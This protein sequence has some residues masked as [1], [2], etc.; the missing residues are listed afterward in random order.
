MSKADFSFIRYSN[1]WE[2]TD[3]LLNALDIRKGE[4]GI[5]IASAGDNTL[6]MLLKEP[7]RIYAFDLNPTQL[8][9][10][11]LKMSCFRC[12]SYRET[13][14]FLGV[15]R[16]ERVPLYSRVREA[17]S[18]QARDYFDSHIEII[19]QGVIHC[20]R[21]ENFFRIFRNYVIPMFSSREEFRSFVR[22]DNLQQQIDFYNEHINNHRLRAMFRIYF[23]YKVMGRLGR[24]SSFYDHVE[25][26]EHS[27]S[28]IRSRFEFG[29]SHAVNAFNPY[30]NYIVCGGYTPQCL[31]LYL[32][33]E[34]FDVIRR[35]LDRITLVQGDLSSLPCDNVDFANLS[36]IFEYMSDEEFGEESARLHKLLSAG[37]RVAYWN[38]QNRRYIGNELLQCDWQLSDSLF[39]QNNSWFYRDFLLYR[40]VAANE[41]NS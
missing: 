5:S 20:G 23:G 37:G 16:G 19:E 31:P 8:Y 33:R 9:C 39:E 1:C 13:L 30:F 27:G 17:I 25:D 10:C 7:E 6:A 2:D 36:D 14:V 41:Q 40:K 18:E 4:T 35:N 3:I 32:R 34:N 24:D 15:I 12:L 28:D 38:M 21:F 26:K 29:I 11:E 22:M